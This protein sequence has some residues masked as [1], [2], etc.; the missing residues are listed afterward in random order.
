MND[1][2][3]QPILFMGVLSLSMMLLM[4]L[5]R[6]PAAKQLETEGVVLQQ[7]SHPSQL[8][9]VFPS[10]VERVA[11]NYNHLWE[12][13][14]L[15]YAVVMVI[16]ALDHTDPM[17]LYSAWAYCGLRFTHSLVQVTINHVWLRFTLFIVSWAA[18]ATMLLREA[19]S[20]LSP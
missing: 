20:A 5:T 3:L 10:R 19:F 1:L 2:I 7:L 8:G 9:G 13:P 17:H 12:Q 4:Y 6:I 11:D 16:W 15:F 14:T 18:L